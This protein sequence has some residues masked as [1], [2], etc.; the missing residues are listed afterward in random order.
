M[1]LKD[2][3]GPQRHSELR[4]GSSGPETPGFPLPLAR[5]AQRGAREAFTLLV[6]CYGFVLCCRNSARESKGLS[7]DSQVSDERQSWDRNQDF[8][9]LKY[10]A[11]WRSR[12]RAW[13]ATDGLT[14]ADP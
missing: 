5:V 10:P 11:A 1:D 4:G 2:K 9:P 14:R 13:Q 3:S 12:L 8:F 6:S 7:P